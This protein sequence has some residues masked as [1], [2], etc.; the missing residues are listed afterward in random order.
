MAVRVSHLS[1][2]KCWMAGS[3]FGIVIIYYVSFLQPQSENSSR[4]YFQIKSLQQ[5]VLLLF[6]NVHDHPKKNRF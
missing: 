5:Q 3:V 1:T 4:I 2:I 6:N